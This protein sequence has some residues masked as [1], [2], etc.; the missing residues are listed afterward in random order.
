MT[1][2]SDIDISVAV[3]LLMSIGIVAVSVWGYFRIRKIT[4]LYFGGAY[5]LFAISHYL[6]LTEGNTP[7]GPEFFAL[8]T[9]GYALV[10]I[11]LFALLQEII[12]RTRSEEDLARLT[13]Q[14]EERVL[15]RTAELARTNA[16]LVSEVSSRT[17]AEERLRQS[18]HE[19]EVLIKEIHHRVKN[20]LQIIVSLLY[21]QS[22]KTGDPD[23]A[24]ALLDSQTRVKSMALIHENLYQSG[25]LASI[26][27]D[28]YLQNLTGNL[29]VAYGADLADIRVITDARDLDLSLT[30]AIPLGLIANELV[31]N[32]FK[33]A[34]DGRESGEITLTGEKDA[35]Q[36]TFVVRDNGRGIPLEVDWEH[37]ESLG[38]NLVRMLVRQLRGKITLD[39]TSGTHFVITFPVTG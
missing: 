33:Y 26:N 5:T 6:L 16:A 1:V 27:F 28:R 15:A 37:T 31:A 14:L 32:A 29:R 19:K 35:S 12:R 36:V 18:L 38:F 21:L 34:F 4:P 20:N 23:C 2:F 39:R 25:D 24:A 7:L 3:N 11:G 13:G 17:I 8:R 9:G 22:R 10:V 30:T